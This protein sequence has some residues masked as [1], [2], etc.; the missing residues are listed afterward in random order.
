MIIRSEKWVIVCSFVQK[1]VSS[2]LKINV[3]D[4]LKRKIEDTLLEWKNTPSHSPLVIMG[5]RQCGKT[6]IVRKF[7]EDNYKYVYYMN[8]IKQPNRIAAFLGSKEVDVILMELSTQ[9]PGANF[10]PGQTCFIF[11]EIQDCPDA[12]TSLKFFKEDGRFDVIAT[13]SLLG[14]LG[15]GEKKKKLKRGKDDDIK[16][17]KN[18]IPVGSEEIVQ[19][20]PLDFEEFLWANGISDQ[21]IDFLKD[22]LRNEKP[23]PI[24]MHTTLKNLLNRYIAVGGLPAAV[25]KLL[26]TGNLSKVNLVLHR[27]LGEYKDDMVKYASDDDKPYIRG[28]FDSITKQLSK[29]YKKFQYNLIKKDGRAEDYAGSLQWLEDAGIIHRCYN[30][31]TTGLPMEGNAI[32]S[33]FKVYI[34]DIG[35]LVAMLGGSTRSDIIQGNLGGFKGAI[36]ENLMADTLHKKGQNLYYYRKESGMEL[37]F[38]VNYKGEC[39]PVEVKARTAKA[40]SL[41]TALKHPDKYH[42]FHAIKFG[43]YNIGREGA[44][45]TLPNYMQFLLDLEP[46]EI[47]LTPIDADAVNSLAK[48]ILFQHNPGSTR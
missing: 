16:L 20:Y 48:E 40:K 18:S 42:I 9:I 46:E 33:T 23:V 6:F 3:I 41:S 8:F 10:V 26:E 34:T 28:C 39:L 17:G 24:G 27:I 14:V 15:Y 36:Y 32:E 19:M 4:M 13:G 38:L 31:E 21:V 2:C 37:D 1:N 12:R 44:L 47:I 5:I 43:D 30:T 22:C 11:D 29:D 7:A 35:L 25:N 45:L